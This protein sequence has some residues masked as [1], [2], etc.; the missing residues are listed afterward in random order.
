MSD[1]SRRIPVVLFAYARPAHLERTLRSLREDGVPLIEAFADGPKAE[2]DTASVAAVRA[3]LRAVDWCEMRLTER[4]ENRGLGRNILA[5]V[6]EIAARHDAFIVWEDDLTCVPGTYAWLCAALR[7]YRD[8]PRVMSVT[9][10]THPRVTPADVCGRPWFD[11]R[12]ECWSWGTWSRAW[13]GMSEETARAKLAAAAKRG[14]GASAYGA[15]LPVMAREEHAKNLWAVR[16]VWHHLQHGGLC[17]RPPWS[18]VEHDGFDAEATNAAS[19]GEWKNPPLQPAPAIPSQWPDPKLHPQSARLWHLAMAAHYPRFARLRNLVPAFVRRGVRRIF[20][21]KATR[22]VA[23]KGG[24]G[25]AERGPGG[26]Q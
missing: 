24:G 23:D 22:V 14:I 1:P 26:R 4:T 13:A 2:A 21:R 16:W 6:T 10:W 7:H 11:G 15:D 5:G 3:R 25:V 12:A 9:G 18:M 8:D 20:P 17:V 19:G